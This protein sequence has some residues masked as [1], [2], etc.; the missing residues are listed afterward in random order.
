MIAHPTSW[1]WLEVGMYLQATDGS[2]WRIDG[3]GRDVGQDGWTLRITNKD[4]KSVDVSRGA[5]APTMVMVPT[6]EE[7][8]AVI[9]N[10]GMVA[11]IKRRVIRM[12]EYRSNP[13]SKWVRAALA[14]H[15]AT[16]HGISITST[17][18]EQN[19]SIDDLLEIHALAH[20]STRPPIIEHV[21]VLGGDL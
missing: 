14:S 7:A 13:D 20:A 15:L 6:P 11:G 5:E 2:V 21:H 19:K 4:G 10:A 16:L 9:V 1:V 12:E 17:A 8:E 3:K 18:H